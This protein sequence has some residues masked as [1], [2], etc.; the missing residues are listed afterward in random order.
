V[1]PLRSSPRPRRRLVRAR[2]GFGL[3][4][5]LI[6]I[7]MLS[8]G[9]LG[10]ASLMATALRRDRLSSTRMEVSSLAEAKFEELRA[11]GALNFTHAL[12]ARLNPG[13]SLTASVAS[14]AD[15]VV[16]L[17][18]RTYDRRWEITSGTPLNTRRV[19]VRVTPRTALRY[20]TRVVQFTTMVVLQ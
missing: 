8:V 17:N 13:G 14:Y 19:T 20:D 9:M 15:S 16:A 12:R 6:A 18:G 7:I 2:A 10:L 1:R 5:L 3:V 11:Y 4:E